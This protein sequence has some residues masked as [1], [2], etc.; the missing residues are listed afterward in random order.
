MVRRIT[1]GKL[2]WKIYGLTW[3]ESISARGNFPVSTDRSYGIRLTKF[4]PFFPIGCVGRENLIKASNFRLIKRL[5]NQ[6]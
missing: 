4:L 3:E 6:T 5:P 1:M 2:A